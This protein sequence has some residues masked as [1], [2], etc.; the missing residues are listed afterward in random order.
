MCIDNEGN[1]VISLPKRELHKPLLKAAQRLQEFTDCSAD[2]T[3]Y[4]R[5]AQMAKTFDVLLAGWIRQSLD[6]FA[7]LCR[8]SREREFPALD[9]ILIALLNAYE[10]VLC[11]DRRCCEFLLPSTITTLSFQLIAF[12]MRTPC[13]IR[14]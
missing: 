13:W 5:L 11:C 8:M 10:R 9:L 1:E 4:T 2:V 14:L 6:A 12:C 7:E 3:H